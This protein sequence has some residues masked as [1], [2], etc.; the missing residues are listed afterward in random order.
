MEKAWT[1]PHRIDWQQYPSV[2][3]ESDDWG[4]CEAS[5]CREDA[6]FIG[7]LWRDRL[8]ISRQVHSTLESPAD[9]ERL[10][11]VLA[12]VRGADAQP[13]VFTA[14]VCVGNPDFDAIRQSGFSEYHDMGIDQG[15]PKGWERGDIVSKWREGIER[16]VFAPEFHSNL[17]HTSPVRWLERLRADGA[18]G[19]VA[20]AAFERG[21]YCQGAHLPEFDGMNVREQS[22]WTRLGLARFQ[23]AVG[24]PP[25]CAI[26]SDAYPQTETVWALHGIR[27]VCLKNCRTNTDQIA[28]YGTKLWNNQDGTVPVGAY[29]PVTDVIYMIRNAFFECALNE[30]QGADDVLPVIRR[31]WSENE[32][33]L[34]S[35]HRVHYAA[36]DPAIAA[37][38]RGELRRLLT[39]LADIPRIRF[40]TTTEVSDLYR[41]GWSL[42]TVGGGH[43]LRKW[44]ADAD[45]I[46]LPFAL[47]HVTSLPDGCEFGCQLDGAEAIA[48]LPEGDYWLD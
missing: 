35:T 30:G 43:I 25:A 34:V 16:G 23:S 27:T 21:I 40:L 17:H 45:P 18:E 39:T 24:Y 5:R 19:D 22:E 42:R 33:A 31:R 20:R 37:R 47:D 1:I 7:A 9:L 10:F 38:G 4:A 46:R 11:D 6:Q 13:A 48:E 8:D 26:T 44:D 14:F 29:E 32:P 15:V 28:V 41:R 3:F 36:L 12:Q 2:V